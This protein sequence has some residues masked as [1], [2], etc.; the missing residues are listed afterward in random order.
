MKHNILT[1]LA[2]LFLFA[3][4]L[5]PASYAGASGLAVSNGAPG[6]LLRVWFSQDGST[7]TKLVPDSQIV[8][9]PYALQAQLAAD[10]VALNGH[11]AGDFLTA[12]QYLGRRWGTRVDTAGDVGEHS[13][14][15]LGADG[16]GLI[17]CYD[18]TNG[19]LKVIKL[20]GLGRR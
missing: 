14:I 9:V 2:L 6:R 19:D 13:S 15:T 3:S 18:H 17:S 7:F 16:L 4:L 5:G 1:I 10:S 11:P 8:S 12:S 20:S